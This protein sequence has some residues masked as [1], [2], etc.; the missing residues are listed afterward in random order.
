MCVCVCVCVCAFNILKLVVLS[1]HV[2]KFNSSGY[3]LS[4][5]MFDFFLPRIG[6]Y[7]TTKKTPSLLDMRLMLLTF[8]YQVRKVSQQAYSVL[9]LCHVINCCHKILVNN[10]KYCNSNV[11]CETLTLA[12]ISKKKLWEP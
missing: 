11:R 6:Q 1:L 10:A 8:I 5:C 2:C 9:S 7:S 3:D 12:C 4:T